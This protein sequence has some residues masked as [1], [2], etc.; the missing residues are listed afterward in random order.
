MTQKKKS[1]RII[2]SPWFILLAI[3][4]ISFTALACNSSKTSDKNNDPLPLLQ[5]PSEDTPNTPNLASEELLKAGPKGL[6][7]AENRKEAPLFELPYAIGN[8]FSLSDYKG[9]VVL[10]D[11]TATWC[12]WCDRQA[13]QVEAVYKKFKGKGLEI[14]AIDCRESRETVLAKYPDGT[15]AYPIVLDEQGTVFSMYSPIFNMSG[16]PTYILLDKEGK[17]AYIQSGYNDNFDSIVSDLV[18]YLLKN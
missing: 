9:K 13:P 5:V 18:N 8:T 17:A 10:L 16:Y 2:L 4:F 14:F 6:I 1:N 3:C 12:H 15:K 11:F 7:P